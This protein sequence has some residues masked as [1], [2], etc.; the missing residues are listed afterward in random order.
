MFHNIKFKFSRLGRLLQTNIKNKNYKRETKMC[1]LTMKMNFLFK[2]FY[3]G[4][5]ML[6]KKKYFGRVKTFIVS[7]ALRN[8]TNIRNKNEMNNNRIE[9]DEP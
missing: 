8:Q 7:S 2:D 6:K 9:T 3:Y 4:M 1:G 5:V